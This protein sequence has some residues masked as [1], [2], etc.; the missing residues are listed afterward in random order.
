ML[1]LGSRILFESNSEASVPDVSLYYSNKGALVAGRFRT[2]RSILES[3]LL[4]IEEIAHGC[5]PQL[6]FD[7]ATDKQ[8]RTSTLNYQYDRKTCV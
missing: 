2:L 7:Y 6:Q 4:C 1:H 8:L 5:R 3:Q